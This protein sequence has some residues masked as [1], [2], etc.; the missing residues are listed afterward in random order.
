MH[1]FAVA[2]PTKWNK[3][4]QAVNLQDSINRFRQQLKTYLH[5]TIVLPPYRDTNM[6]KGFFSEN[7]LS[8]L[9]YQHLR[10]CFHQF[11]PLLMLHITTTATN[12]K[13]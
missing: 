13:K 5:T 12:L 7:G 2:A 6:D 1:S 3:L 10:G 11:G 8:L 4:P 9:R